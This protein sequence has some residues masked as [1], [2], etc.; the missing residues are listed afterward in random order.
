MKKPKISFN[1][2]A[3]LGF[4]LRNVEK[5]L[6]A[7]IGLF[8]CTLAWGGVDAL[9]S[10]RPSGEQTPQKI[11]E[12]ARVTE[13]HIVSVKIPPE[14]RLTKERGLAEAAQVFKARILLDERQ[15]N[16]SRWAIPLLADN[17]L[18]LAFAGQ[19]LQI[20][21]VANLYLPHR[22]TL[23]QRRPTGSDRRHDLGVLLR[24]ALQGCVVRHAVLDPGNVPQPFVPERAPQRRGALL[25]RMKHGLDLDSG[26]AL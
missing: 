3:V 14:D 7:A 13:E 16:T 25:A 19:S 1:K 23:Q 20:L 10:M 2:D 8:A 6:A 15:A 24:N 18:G 21:Q 22:R 5:M 4:L 9:R 26:T 17:D 11:K 12:D